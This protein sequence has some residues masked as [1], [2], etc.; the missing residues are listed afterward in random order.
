M[1]ERPGDPWAK[2]GPRVRTARVPGDKMAPECE[3][4]GCP[5]TKRVKIANAFSGETS[6]E[7]AIERF[8]PF[9]SRMTAHVFPGQSLVLEGSLFRAKPAPRPCRQPAPDALR[10]S[11]TLW[12]RFGPQAPAHSHSGPVLVRQPLAVRTLGPF[13]PTDLLAVRT[14]GP[15]W[16]NSGHHP[17]SA[18]HPP[19]TW[20][21]ERTAGPRSWPFRKRRCC[22]SVASLADSTC[23]QLPG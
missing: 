15:I 21:A 12:A 18:L 16:P 1:C 7:S 5:V 9:T 19:G 23:G 14:P 10:F 17:L 2:N 13:W 11:F 20:P 22:T 4:R 8:V 6:P 3:P